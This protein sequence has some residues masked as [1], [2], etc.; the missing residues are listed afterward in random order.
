MFSNRLD[1]RFE[2]RSGNAS[3]SSSEIDSEYEDVPLPWT[4][5]KLK[6][7]RRNQLRPP[8]TTL[9]LPL[10]PSNVAVPADLDTGQ[11][12]P[13]TRAKVKEGRDALRRS[14]VSEHVPPHAQPHCPNPFPA[15]TADSQH[16]FDNE[17]LK[18]ASDFGSQSSL[19]LNSDGFLGFENDS[20]VDLEENPRSASPVVETYPGAVKVF[21]KGIDTLQDVDNMDMYAEERKKNIFHPF[22]DAD[23]FAMAAWLNESGASM[24]YIDEFL[25]LPMV[26]IILSL[27]IY[28]RF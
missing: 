24:A 15:S 9:P 16:L 6:R 13:W 12:L 10:N 23:D 7:K 26:N 22:K 27:I 17:S 5:K 1:T 4:S 21:G 25:K 11:Y 19:S 8:D 28:S 14:G 2:T 18:A 3:D 20:D